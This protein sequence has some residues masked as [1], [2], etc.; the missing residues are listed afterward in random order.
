[1]LRWW[2]RLVL[3]LVAGAAAARGV[4]FPS[5]GIKVCTSDGGGEDEC[6]DKLLVDAFVLPTTQGVWQLEVTIAAGTTVGQPGSDVPWKTG[7]PI[8]ISIEASNER[9]QVDLGV[10]PS[11]GSFRNAYVARSTLPAG[12][13]CP[14]R[15]SCCD[16]GGELA[17]YEARNNATV[18][19]RYEMS[20]SELLFDI[21]VV[22]EQAETGLREVIRLTDSVRGATNSLLDARLVSANPAATLFGL[23]SLSLVAEA[24]DAAGDT[25]MFVANTEFG[26]EANEI[27]LDTET[28]YRGGIS[29]CGWDDLGRY[30]RPEVASDTFDQL[31]V[32]RTDT[33]ASRWGCPIDSVN[34]EVE[35]GGRL[36]VVCP[37]R[38]ATYQ[39]VLEL[40]VA[41]FR[42]VKLVGEPR[43]LDYDVLPLGELDEKLRVFVDIANVGEQR[44][45]FEVRMSSCTGF[46][47]GS[48][49]DVFNARLPDPQFLNIQPQETRR[50]LFEL[51]P[52]TVR[53]I[54]G[55]CTFRVFQYGEL[56]GD[57]IIE[58]DTSIFNYS[59]VDPPPDNPSPPPVADDVECEAPLQVVTM[60]DGSTLCETPCTE[61]ETWAGI[62]CLPVTCSSKYGDE[63]PLYDE[64]LRLCVPTP[65]CGPG[66]VS[67]GGIQCVNA[68]DAGSVL[69]GSGG[70]LP[71]CSGNGV[72]NADN[73]TCTCNEGY[74]T[75]PDQDVL[76]DFRWCSV[77]VFLNTGEGGGQTL[78]LNAGLLMNVFVLLLLCLCCC[79]CCCRRYMRK[80]SER[81]RRARRKERRRKRRAADSSSSDDDS[82]D[83]NEMEEER[84][85]KKKKKKEDKVEIEI[86]EEKKEPKKAPPPLPPRPAAIPAAAA[87]MLAR[88]LSSARTVE[89]LEAGAEYI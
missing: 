55:S 12:S 44:G 60:A 18:Y 13:S 10:S 52:T 58:F 4:I 43:F 66:E 48:D 26:S 5:Y 49:L 87:A 37:E 35:D 86:E 64:T 16:E 31:S 79:R 69:I 9:L 36:A 83:D 67:L 39:L 84:K 33:S 8:R 19:S 54:T 27:G 68:S 42:I 72:V 70:A 75:D 47:D 53:D 7:A 11:V 61:D 28:L 50:A 80:R 81:K 2:L 78:Q 29:Q 32:D 22:V 59:P 73:V 25:H 62:L 17:V 38:P 82:S 77:Q 20:G 65:T 41:E 6:A 1:M 88:Q 71:N 45:L 85:P 40:D 21:D 3:A 51:E 23:A 30:T 15:A 46:P 56:D 74:G 76:L 57:L 34:T 63:R 24:G 14:S 89:L